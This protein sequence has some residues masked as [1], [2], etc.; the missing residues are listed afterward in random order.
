MY[1]VLMP[2]ST[3]I[4]SWSAPLN[5]MRYYQLI[6][7]HKEFSE[8]GTRFGRNSLTAVVFISFPL[9]E[10]INRQDNRLRESD[11][12]KQLGNMFKNDK[13]LLKLSYTM[14]SLD[15]NGNT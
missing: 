3:L 4:A 9:T 14:D 5:K 11:W 12:V 15:Y 7:P 1:A 8:K 2:L 13:S 10:L 6:P